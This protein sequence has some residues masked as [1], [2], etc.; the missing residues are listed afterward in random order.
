M[1]DSILS[2]GI[3]INAS[4]FSLRLVYQDIHLAILFGHSK[5]NGLVTTQIVN[6]QSSFAIS[7]I[8][9]AAQVPVQPH[10]QQVINIIFAHSSNLLISSLDSSAACFQISG[11]DQAQSHFVIS[12]Q[13]FSLCSARDE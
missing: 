13:I 5:E 6:A 8:T 11:L 1:I 2:F 12:F 3:V 4:T 7:A 10:N 9:G